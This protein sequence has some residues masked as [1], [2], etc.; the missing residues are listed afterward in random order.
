MSRLRP[1]SV[2]ASVP[3]QARG[4]GAEAST[5]VGILGVRTPGLGTWLSL[6]P[7]V[8]ALPLTPPL[9]VIGEGANHR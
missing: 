5:A 4:G 8:P 1:T 7:M 9:K 2:D 3:P 6:F